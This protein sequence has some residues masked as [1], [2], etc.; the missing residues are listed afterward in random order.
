MRVLLFAFI[1]LSLGSCSKYDEG[2][3]SAESKKSRLV[4]NW[5]MFKLTAN[6]FD[7]TS[8]KMITGVDI[9]SNNTFTV[10]GEVNGTPTSSNAIWAFDS[11]KSHVLVTNG[12]GSVD[13]YEIIKLESDSMKLRIIGDNGVT[14][15]H[16]YQSA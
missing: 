1:I 16:E 13:S 8:Y 9:H 2:K 10:Y 4:N 12:D 14:F 6:G 11:D 5:V 3:A 7:I 15:I